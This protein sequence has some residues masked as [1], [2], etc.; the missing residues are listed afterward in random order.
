MTDESAS[1]GGGYLCCPK[2]TGQ[3]PV[4][5]LPR[6]EN[7][8][9]RT[10][11]DKKSVRK[12]HG[13]H[14]PPAKGMGERV[15]LL[16]GLLSLL[17]AA[18]EVRH[19]DDEHRATSDPSEGH[20]VKT[21]EREAGAFLVLDGKGNGAATRR[22]IGDETRTI[23]GCGHRQR[24]L[25]LILIKTR[26]SNGEREF[27][28]GVIAGERMGL[29]DRV[30]ASIEALDADF[31]LIISRKSISSIAQRTVHLDILGAGALVG[32]LGRGAGRRA[33]HGHRTHRNTSPP[34]LQLGKCRP[35]AREGPRG[36]SANCGNGLSAQYVQLRS[37]IN[38]RNRPY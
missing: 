7:G 37:E 25:A 34:F 32:S 14:I 38:R 11:M 2:R 8:K 28:H 31:A 13:H 23:L 15:L 3:T 27:G 26:G 9:A 16:L 24:I 6:K 22:G 5:S 17:T 30:S 10:S 35:G 18:D 33:E 1:D 36:L 4:R 19:A 21:G 12:S 20:A 29:L